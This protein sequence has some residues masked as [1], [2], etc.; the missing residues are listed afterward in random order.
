MNIRAWAVTILVVVIFLAFVV[1]ISLWILPKLG[2]LGAP[3]T[4]YLIWGA[5]NLFIILA[6]IR[7]LIAIY[8]FVEQRL[9]APDLCLWLDKKGQDKMVHEL[10]KYWNLLLENKG[11]KTAR[12][13]SARMVFIMP[14]RVGGNRVDRVELVK[15]ATPHAH[16][17][18]KA[19]RGDWIEYAFE[20]GRDFIGNGKDTVEIGAF[21]LHFSPRE[22]S[23]GELKSEYQIEYEL[24]CEGM[25]PGK[26]T[27]LVT[28]PKQL[29]GSID[30]LVPF[31]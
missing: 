21:R 9:I 22:Y 25:A 17:W 18:H 20:G 30:I 8:E 31:L 10:D 1:W 26:G 19:Y 16:K 23:Y 4:A 14:P 28:L 6:S 24:R 2:E 29:Y 11:D 3:W 13:V 12:H 5:A 15:A 27:L 7:S